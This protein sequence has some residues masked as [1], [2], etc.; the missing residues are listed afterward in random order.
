MHTYI[1]PPIPI[2]GS[3]GIK[4]KINLS[5]IFMELQ[6]L[7]VDFIV[8]NWLRPHS[9]LSIPSELVNLIFKFSNDYERWDKNLTSPTFLLKN[10]HTIECL[11][12][13]VSDGSNSYLQTTISNK[14]ITNKT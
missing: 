13:S 7:F 6:V 14:N 2:V 5:L 1:F 8:H 3:H 9:T 11:E 4:N 12:D 10:N